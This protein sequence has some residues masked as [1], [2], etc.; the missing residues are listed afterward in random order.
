[1][2][3]LDIGT[4]HFSLP[5][6]ML[7][8][9]WLLF[10][11]VWFMDIVDATQ[12]ITITVKLPPTSD[13]G[14]CQSCLTDIAGVNR[15]SFAP[16]FV[17]NSNRPR[18]RENF[19]SSGCASSFLQAKVD[20]H[21][22]VPC[23]SMTIT[24]SEPINTD[25]SVSDSSYVDVH[26]LKRLCVLTHSAESLYCGSYLKMRSGSPSIQKSRL[27]TKEEQGRYLHVLYT[28]QRTV[29]KPCRLSGICTGPS[30][31]SNVRFRPPKYAF[32]EKPNY[33]AAHYGLHHTTE[34]ICVNVRF[35]PG[36]YQTSTSHDLRT[37]CLD[38]ITNEH[39][40]W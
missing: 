1:M 23:G 29:F 40:E 9:H 38:C 8:Q 12:P 16:S 18:V 24:G 32:V 35:P 31:L 2:I 39:P 28:N 26:E 11:G 4:M 13:L 19:Q 17:H 6:V 21:N 30:W 37:N 15:L 14:K 34:L 10:C 5:L 27:V 33:L 7:H 36:C 3:S 22:D 25:T 20:C